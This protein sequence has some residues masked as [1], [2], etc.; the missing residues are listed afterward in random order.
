MK[1]ILIITAIII[2]I[3]VINKENKED[4][5]IIPNNAIRFRVIANSNSIE[6]Q[7][8]K[9]KVSKIS[10]EYIYNLTKNS[11][12]SKEAKRILLENKTNIENYVQNYLDINN[13]DEEFKINIGNNYFPN[14]T[15]KGVEYQAGY[16]DSVVIDL[17]K[18]EGLN[19][20]CIIYP[21]LCLIDEK[22]ED[23]EY[24]SLA[25]EILSNFDM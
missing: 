16:Y 18:S 4:I 19:W 14:K 3:C 21:P 25:S 10:Q 20:W 9:N 7:L 6:D 1:K 24:T 12:S 11:K 2:S 5:V 22:T 8:N 13:I 23:I 17:G 15:F